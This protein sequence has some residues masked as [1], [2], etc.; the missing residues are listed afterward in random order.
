LESGA[1]LDAR[2]RG[3]A[4]IFALVL[5]ALV[6]TRAF[7]YD[8][9]HP[10]VPIDN[11][12]LISGRTILRAPRVDQCDELL[13]QVPIVDDWGNRELRPDLRKPPRRHVAFFYRRP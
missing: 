9:A 13:E 5:V 1:D 2:H 12:I 10:L 3:V 4:R 6:A 7:A 11:S 8:A